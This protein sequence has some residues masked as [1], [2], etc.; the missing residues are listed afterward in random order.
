M[1]CALDRIQASDG[2]GDGV[3]YP[4][5]CP[6]Y[7]P[8]GCAGRGVGCGVGDCLGAGGGRGYDGF[9]GLDRFGYGFAGVGVGGVVDERAVAG[10]YAITSGFVESGRG[11]CG[12][13]W[14]GAPVRQRGRRDA[15]PLTG[16]H[17]AIWRRQ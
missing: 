2:N 15:N 1:A 10:Y 9:S 6:L 11:N 3:S 17:L 14:T 12:C 8:G 5:L 4:R 16:Q 13:D 7:R